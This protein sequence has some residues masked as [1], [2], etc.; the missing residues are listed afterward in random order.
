VRAPGEPSIAVVVCVDW[1][2]TAEQRRALED[3]AARLTAQSRG[4][5]TVDV[6]GELRG[7]FH[8][9][10]GAWRILATPSDT[11]FVAALDQRFRHPVLGW[12]NDTTMDI[13][14]VSDRLNRP[15][16]FL[17]VAMHELA[18]A[19]GAQ[20]LADHNALMWRFTVPESP[21][22]LQIADER[23]LYRVAMKVTQ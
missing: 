18:H 13:H 14:I 6:I 1:G 21:T 17:H 22:T 5:L 7:D 3:A 12:A 10:S 16:A 2:F 4:W 8:V 23:E 20:H 19:A 11:E 9:P 15:S